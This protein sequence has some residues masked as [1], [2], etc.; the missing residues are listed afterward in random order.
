MESDVDICVLCENTFFSDYT[1]TPGVN[2]NLLGFSP[3]TYSFAELKQDV[4]AALVAKFGRLAVKRGNKAFDIKENTYRVAADVVPT[5]EGRL[6]YKDQSGG[7]D[8]Y[9][10][11]VLQCD[12]D[13][14]TI[15]NWP[16][17]HYANG[18][19]RHDATIQQFKKKVRIL[20]N[21]CNEM[22][23]VG[24]VSAKS[25]A[26]FLLE[27]LVYNCPDEVFTQST[28]YD[29]IKSVITYLLDVTETD[30]KAKRMLEV[31]NIKYLFHDSQ[32]WK[33]ADVYDFLLS[34]WNYAGF[35]S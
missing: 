20:K 35:G 4:E 11:I 13:G 9:S 5:F 32:P 19:K 15:Y 26:S 31:N 30:E 17:Q 27:S 28:H 1:H 16:E 18:D 34:A 3:A 21:L 25:M 2:D 29:D 12:S 10:G 22:A 7:L 8:Y 6:Y 14:G 23:A 24:I 33:R